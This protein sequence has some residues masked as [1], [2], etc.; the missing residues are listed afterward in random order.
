LPTWLPRIL[1]RI[2]D[3]AGAGR[4]R[5]TVKVAD[6]LSLLSLDAR[7][8]VEVLCALSAADADGRVRSRDIGEWMYVFKPTVGQMV[9]YLKIAVRDDCIVVSFHEDEAEHDDFA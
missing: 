8:A 4:V 3:L 1:R 2:R 7:D 5:F 6:E 9:L